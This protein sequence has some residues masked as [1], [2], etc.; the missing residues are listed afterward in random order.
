VSIARWGKDMLEALGYQ[1]EIFTNASEA[2]DSFTQNPDR[3]DVLV[4]DQTMPSMTGEMLAKQVLHLRPS[5]PVILCSGFS[6]TMNEKKAE[7]MGLKAYLTKP[8]LMDEMARALQAAIPRKA[9]R[10]PA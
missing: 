4:T 6:Y 3:F 10:N 8:V 7:A 5:F 1:V 9:I 2:L